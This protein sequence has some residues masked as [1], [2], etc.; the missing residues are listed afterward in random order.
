M[1]IGGYYSFQGING[2]ARYHRTPV[3]EVLPVECLP[4]DDRVEVPEGFAAE[5]SAATIRS[6]TAWAAPGRLCSASTR[7]S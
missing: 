3:E 2:G 6:S 4:Y 1:M 5:W 7:S